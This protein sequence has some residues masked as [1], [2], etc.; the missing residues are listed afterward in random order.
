MNM[1]MMVIRLPRVNMMLRE[2]EERKRKEKTKPRGHEE[3]GQ[4]Q[5]WVMVGPAGVLPLLLLLRGH[6]VFPFSSY[7]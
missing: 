2:V 7:C 5:S 4:S 1:M 3:R 6:L